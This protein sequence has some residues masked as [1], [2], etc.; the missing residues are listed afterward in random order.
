MLKEIEDKPKTSNNDKLTGLKKI[1]IDII[2]STSVNTHSTHV[3]RQW[4]V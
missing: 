4:R 2:S 3:E 1:Y